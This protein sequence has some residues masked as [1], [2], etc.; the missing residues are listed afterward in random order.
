VRPP[1]GVPDV[2]Y[3]VNRELLD[4]GVGAAYACVN[5]AVEESTLADRHGDALLPQ[6]NFVREQLAAGD[7]LVVSVG[8]N[9]VA[10]RPSAATVLAM[11]FLTR[12]PIS[13]IRSGWAPGS[14]HFVTMFKD[15]TAAYVRTVMA[16]RA[17]P[18]RVVVCSLYY[19]DVVPG[20]SWA[21][22]T[23][24]LLGYDANPAKLQAAIAAIHEFAHR[25]LTSVD[26]VE[27][28]AVPF[29]RCMDGSDRADYEQRV[30]PSAQGGRKM[31]AMI[32]DA[33]LGA[34]AQQE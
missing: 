24:R 12:S 15:R 2:A 16:G 22:T 32:V 3:W 8:G 25:T 17:K 6:D 4:R 5:A 13:L 7:T 9:D 27:V 14:S 34:G 31:A 29:F 21:D 23:L 18:R 26:G 33:V 10:L 28:V 20:G 1:N 11:L 19:L 30:E